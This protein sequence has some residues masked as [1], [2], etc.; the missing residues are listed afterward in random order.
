MLV[1]WTQKALDNLE[2]AVE[3]IAADNPTAASGVAQK[4]WN[5]AQL[6]VDQPGMGR[7]GR[8]SDTR[9]LIIAGLP[10]ILPYI[11]KEGVVFILR[12]MHSSMKWPQEF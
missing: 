11:E 5:T 1:K 10:Y 2:D 7:P 9:E 3:Y 6:L 4:I 12:V 8:V